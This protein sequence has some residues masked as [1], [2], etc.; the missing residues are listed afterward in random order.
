M[1]GHPAS[2]DIDDPTPRRVFAGSIYENSC[3][4]IGFDWLV[5]AGD[6]ELKTLRDLFS[7]AILVAF[8]QKERRSDDGNALKW[9]IEHRSFKFAF[10]AVIEDPRV[11]ITSHGAHE[12]EM[13]HVMGVA[14][15]RKLL[16]IS[17]IDVTKTIFTAGL[18]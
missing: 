4:D 16:R 9:H 5:F 1:L 15:L 13:M 8:S 11:G 14:Y 2:A 3:H 17:E 6:E 18:F 12:K 7:T 10:H